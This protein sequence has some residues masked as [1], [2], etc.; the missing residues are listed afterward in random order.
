[1][2][3]HKTCSWQRLNVQWDSVLLLHSEPWVL[4]FQLSSYMFLS[5]AS[6][7]CQTHIDLT[8]QPLHSTVFQFTVHPVENL[9][10]KKKNKIRRLQ[11]LKSTKMSSTVISKYCDSG[12]ILVLLAVHSFKFIFQMKIRLQAVIRFTSPLLKGKRNPE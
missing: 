4:P 2:C 10:K 9:V 8:F 11:G 5:A 6:V 1:M 3:C 12:G 7:H